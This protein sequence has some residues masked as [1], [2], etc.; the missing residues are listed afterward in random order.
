MQWKNTET[1]TFAGSDG[2]GIT[3]PDV[4]ETLQLTD[5]G[6]NVLAT[7]TKAVDGTVTLALTGNLSVTGDASVSGNVTETITEA[8][9]SLSDNTTANASTT[10]HGFLRKLSNVATEVMVGTG[11]WATIA[12]IL[13]YTPMA[14]IVSVDNTIPR[15]DGIAGAVQQSGWTINDSHAL[16]PNTDNVSDIGNGSV[17]PRDVNVSRKVVVGK[18]SVATGQIDLA[19]TTSGVISVKVADAAGTRT[20]T[21]ADP[22]V[23]SQFALQEA[24]TVAAEDGAIAVKSGVVVITKGSAAAL[25]IAD[26]TATT[27]DFKILKIIAATAHAHTVSN[28]AGSGFNAGGAGTDVGTFG[29]AKGDNIVLMAYQ[30]DW[31]VISKV[32]VTL[33]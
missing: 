18:A 15:F 23:A 19:G 16:N 14:S 11:V 12:T 10:K 5:R 30:G 32:N 28:A 24:P 4:V 31:F 8:E 29:G 26:P 17:N 20:L 25:T 3:G 22:G 27:D 2:T 21:I 33:G 6:G 7:F 9:L 13:G 1:P